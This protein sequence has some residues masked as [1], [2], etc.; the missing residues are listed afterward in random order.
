MLQARKCNTKE[1]SLLLL[2][3]KINNQEYAGSFSGKD[4]KT[5]SKTQFNV[6]FKITFHPSQPGKK[7]KKLS[8]RVWQL[9][10]MKQLLTIFKQKL[11]SEFQLI[12]LLC[13]HKVQDL[14]NLLSYRKVAKKTRAKSVLL[15]IKQTLQLDHCLFKWPRIC[16]GN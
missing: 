5:K 3:V 15:H 16:F 4:P 7:S 6:C 2:S 8:A 1:L 9:L 14:D 10:L 13:Y 11:A 12:G